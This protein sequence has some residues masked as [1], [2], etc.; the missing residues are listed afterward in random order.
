MRIRPLGNPVFELESGFVG[1][2][3]RQDLVGFCMTVVQQPRNPLRNRVRFAA[4]RRRNHQHMPV[5]ALEL[6]DAALAVR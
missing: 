1:I 2:G 5:E 4:A 6:N 3:Q